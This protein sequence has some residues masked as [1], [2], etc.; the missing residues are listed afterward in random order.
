MINNITDSD[1]SIKLK[2]LYKKHCGYYFSF[3]KSIYAPSKTITLNLLYK[4][5][6]TKKTSRNK[7]H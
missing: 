5:S 1:K 3:L 7:T 4:S 6:N 2:D